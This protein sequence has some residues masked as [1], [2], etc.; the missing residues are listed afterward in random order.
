MLKKFRET[1]RDGRRTNAHTGDNW[2]VSKQANRERAVS[3]YQR[4]HSNRMSAPKQMVEKYS[5]QLQELRRTFQA[6]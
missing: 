3:E 2:R 6:K 4:T 5:D 1:M